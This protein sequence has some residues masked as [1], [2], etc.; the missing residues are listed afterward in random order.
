MLI[1]IS[2]FDK[3][4]KFQAVLLKGPRDISD[5]PKKISK[6]DLLLDNHEKNL[7]FRIS[8]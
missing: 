1:D 7:R 6:N 5:Y 3:D 4:K 2:T 8:R